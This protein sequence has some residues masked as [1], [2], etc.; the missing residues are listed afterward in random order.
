LSYMTPKNP[1]GTER[2]ADAPGTARSST[3]SAAANAVAG[4]VTG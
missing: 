1:C 3:A 4:L 2:A